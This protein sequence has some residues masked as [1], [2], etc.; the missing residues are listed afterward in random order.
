MTTSTKKQSLRMQR[1]LQRLLQHHLVLAVISTALILVG[2]VFVGS[3]NTMFRMSMATAYTSLALLGATL[4]VGPLNILRSRPNPVS[5]DLRRDIGIWAG[6]VGLFHVVVGLQVHL[7]GN[8]L[9]Y[10][11][12]SLESARRLSPGPPALAPRAPGS[13][14]ARPPRSRRPRGRPGPRGAGCRWRGRRGSTAASPGH[15]TAGRRGRWR[16]PRPGSGTGGARP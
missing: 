16:R 9:Q 5:T 3:D 11:F 4:F 15:A 13:S 7:R 12:L 8:M 2:Y 1:L 14:R 10:F 6:I